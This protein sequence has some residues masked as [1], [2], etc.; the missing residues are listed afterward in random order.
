M[1]LLGL[2]VAGDGAAASKALAHN[3][4]ASHA[5]EWNREWQRAQA[6]AWLHATPAPHGAVHGVLAWSGMQQAAAARLA[7]AFCPCGPTYVEQGTWRSAGTATAATVSNALRSMTPNPASTG[8]A[9]DAPPEA[10]DVF[11]PPRIAGSAAGAKPVAPEHA[12]RNAPLAAAAT[13]PGEPAP[14]RLHVEQGADGLHVWI[15]ADGDEAAVCAQAA[16]VLAELRRAEHLP[17]LRLASLVC[18]GQTFYTRDTGNTPRQEN[19]T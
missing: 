14:L 19:A 5:Q 1:I 16:A 10:S 3:G 18:N 11:A 9:V 7:P 12:L 4:L 13:R 17:A 15:G 8:A 2:P 6:R